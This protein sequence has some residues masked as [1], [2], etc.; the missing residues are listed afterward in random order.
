MAMTE[1]ER[2]K[3]LCE[4][5]DALLVTSGAGMG[6]DSGLPD[7][8]GNQGFWN[9]YPAYEKLGFNFVEMANPSHFRSD[10]E[11]GWGF[12]GHRRNLY[13]NTTPH[14]GF[15]RLLQFGRALPHGYFAFTSNV[16]GHFQHAGFEPERVIECHGSIGHLQ[17]A[18]D[19][20]GKVWRAPDDEIDV[21]EITMRAHPDSI[22][23]CPDCGDIARP[24][25]LMFGDASWNGSRFDHQH[26]NYQTWLRE[27]IDADTSLVILEFGAGTS[28]PTVRH[29]SET[30]C[31]G[32]PKASL[33]RV[34]PREPETGLEG[35]SLPIGALE[36]I[37]Q[38]L[39]PAAPLP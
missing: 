2:A 22:P 23:R 4:E 21:D 24:N 12:Y 17:C 37:G 34:N 31:D 1:V 35:V 32:I 25:I 27:V 30:I 10:P 20:R 29:Q 7:F 15:D 28:V 13:R 16:D 19:C 14:R 39:P 9:A 18:S 36:A 3:Q 33:V 5:A 11:L 8:R 38:I 26:E 6:V